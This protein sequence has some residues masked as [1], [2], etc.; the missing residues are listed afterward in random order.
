[1]SLRQTVKVTLTLDVPARDWDK[2]RHQGRAVQVG[3]DDWEVDPPVTFREDLECAIW[4]V[5]QDGLFDLD[6][7]MFVSPQLVP[8]GEPYEDTRPIEPVGPDGSPF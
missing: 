8:E 2:L 3:P 6:A 1:M 5:I 4:N 7:Y